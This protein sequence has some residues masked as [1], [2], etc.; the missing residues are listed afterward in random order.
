V[1]F[2][3][4][5]Q[6]RRVSD[7]VRV[8]I[9]FCKWVSFRV[10]SDFF[11]GSDFFCF[12]CTRRW[13]MK[14]APKPVLRGSGLGHGCKNTPEPAPVGCK[15]RGLPETQTWT[16]IHTQIDR[17]CRAGSIA[18]LWNQPK[19]NGTMCLS[20]FLHIII[21]SKLINTFCSQGNADH[22]KKH[23]FLKNMYIIRIL[24]IYLSRSHG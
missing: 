19:R 4:R 22:T 18:T 17:G 20:Y 24:L 12:G 9:G 1:K 8:S 21:S 3:T 2:G 5:T 23:L 13:K 10:F 14:P 7:Q 6:T 15:T 11:Q 16:T